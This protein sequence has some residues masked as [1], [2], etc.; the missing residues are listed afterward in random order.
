MEDSDGDNSDTDEKPKKKKDR[1]KGM[2]TFTKNIRRK[3]TQIIS[4]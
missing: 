4:L 3:T 2:K 1:M